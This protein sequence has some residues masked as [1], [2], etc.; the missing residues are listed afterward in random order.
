MAARLPL[1]CR[2]GG[3]PGR[4]AEQREGGGGLLT[5]SLPF[6]LSSFR[7]SGVVVFEGKRKWRHLSL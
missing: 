3:R 6:F 4:L 2:L 5:L 7:T 1:V